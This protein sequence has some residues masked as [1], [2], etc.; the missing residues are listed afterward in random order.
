MTRKALVTGGSRGIGA[1]I[2]QDLAE[3]GIQVTIASRKTETL[4]NLLNSLPGEGHSKFEIDFHSQSH[5]PTF[6]DFIGNSEFD[7]I[8]NNA[9]G[10]LGLT[11]PLGDY[12][13]F[14]Q[15]LEFNLGLAIDI[16]A[17][18]LPGMIKRKWGRITHVSSIS[19]LENQGPPQY[20]A[21]KAA[22]NAY[23]RSVGRYVASDGVVM[24]G[25]MPGAVMTA[26]GY[27]DEVMRERPEHGEKFL[28]ERMAIKRFG[29]T[30]EISSIVSFLVSESA[31]FMTGSIVLAD[32]GQGR[33]FQ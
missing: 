22:L 32:G 19:A 33:T 9:G 2:V 31:S 14:Q 24:T 1:G 18:A 8:V 17:R 21:A 13:T 25:V 23:I 27:W 15:V 16:N 11:N 26:G 28:Q 5:L 12:S 30:E 3:L 7:I 29:E 6:L 4:S 20:C 10:N